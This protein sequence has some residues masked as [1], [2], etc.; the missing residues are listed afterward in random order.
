MEIAVLLTCHNRKEKTVTGL[1]SLF[2]A[3]LP[4]N[5]SLEVFVVDD[6]ST[7][8]TSEAIR[9]KF[10]QIN[11]IEG[12]GNL[13]W[14]RGMHLAWKTASNTNNYDFYLW[15]ND[16]VILFNDSIITMLN[17]Y[18][19]KSN[20]VICGTMIS[21]VNGEITYGGRC[22]NS[23]LIEPN[24][25]TPM[26]CHLINGNCV[27]I[28]R[29]IFYKTGF[30]DEFFHHAIG[31]FD[32]GLRVIKNGYEC[33]VSTKNIGY[34]NDHISLPEWCQKEHNLLKRIKSLYSPLGNSHPYYFFIY[35]RRHFGLLKALKHFFSIHL[36]LIFPELW[37]K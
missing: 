26:K 28:S 29:E 8:G 23:N 18:S 13:Y 34:C 31:D 3:N 2:N 6:G 4:S 11:I 14:N 22:E 15:L 19:K 17:D 9:K 24:K 12:N 1:D 20:S 10:P 27:L 36:R 30:L 25:K 32:Y 33:R 5:Y 16:D 7:D 37:T 35:E 21:E